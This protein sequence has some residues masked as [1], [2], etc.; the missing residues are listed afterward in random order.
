MH[1]IVNG[2]MSHRCLSLSNLTLMMW[3]HK[4][5]TTAVNIKFLTKVLSSHS[6]TLTM[7]ARESFFW[8]SLLLVICWHQ[9]RPTHD[10][11]WLC[12]L[13]KGKVCLILL[14]ANTC[15]GITRGILDVLKCATRENTI[16][17]I[18]VVLLNIEIYRAV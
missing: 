10:V 13:P 12:L 6:G 5:H 11:F 1:P 16:L 15:K 2:W 17:I 18:L 9:P 4:V 3:E 7:P 8:Y 14:L